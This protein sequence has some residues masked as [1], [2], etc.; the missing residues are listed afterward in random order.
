MSTL[1]NLQGNSNSLHLLLSMSIRCRLAKSH[2]W[3]M[4]PL[5]LPTN[6]FTC[7]FTTT[8]HKVYIVLAILV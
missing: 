6:S 4:A 3:H 1:S 2:G 7:S 8:I 5:V